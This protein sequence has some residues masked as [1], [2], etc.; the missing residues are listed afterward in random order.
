[1]NKPDVIIKDEQYIKNIVVAEEQFMKDHGRYL[2]MLKSHNTIPKDKTAT[3]PTKNEKPTDQIESWDDL[4]I[5][6]NDMKTCVSIDIYTGPLGNGFL[7]HNFIKKDNFI[8]I[9]TIDYGP[10]GRNLEWIKLLNDKF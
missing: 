8:W 4:C 3:K 2:Q 10:E 5:L 1:M 6:P 9:S 7:I